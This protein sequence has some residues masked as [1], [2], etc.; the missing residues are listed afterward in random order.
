[1]QKKR[2]ICVVTG[3]RAEYGIL[4]SL[5]SELRKSDQFQ[6]QI[7]A[8]G[9]HLEKTLGYTITEI[10]NDGYV[11]DYRV[12]IDLKDFSEKSILASISKTVSGFGEAF[13]RLS[14]DLIFFV[15]DRYEIL[16]VAQAALIL[17]IPMAH[18]GGGD[19]TH[20]AYDDAIRHSLT[21]MAHLHFVTSEVSKKRV[22]QLGEDPARVFN[23][24]H[25]V[26]DDFLKPSKFATKLEFFNSIGFSP[27]ELNLLVTYH[28]ET[29]SQTKPEQQISEL[30][31]AL[32]RF[33]SSNGIIITMPG[34]EPGTAEIIKELNK[35]ADEFSNTVKVY[36]SLGYQRY[37]DALR[38][39]DLVIGNSSSG[40]FEA[41][42]FKKSTVN[43][44]DRQK[45]RMH[46]HSVYSCRSNADEIFQ[47]I[48]KA[49]SLKDSINYETLF[50]NGS[51]AQNII[52]TLS[53][54]DDFSF[55]L[56][57]EFV[58]LQIF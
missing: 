27:C 43:I 9:S 25:L 32:R 6:L 29:L 38:Y 48:N 19:V 17:K 31:V 1:M 2:K 11:V 22:L 42:Y 7:I 20:G 53:K 45:G 8:T 55:L 52:N 4:T 14:P 40:I 47:T 46:P 21:K 30:L 37:M 12:P 24:G 56:K 23:H 16:G 49:L 57:K 26:V 35:F 18:F 50:G 58:D 34:A 36:Q 44:G 13:T 3:T 15:G 54:I 10:E 5:L 39:C 33:A 41:A 28:P 51:T